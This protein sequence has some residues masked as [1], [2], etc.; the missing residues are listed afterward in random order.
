MVIRDVVSFI[1]FSVSVGPCSGRKSLIPFY[2]TVTDKPT[3]SC[4]VQPMYLRYKSS[5]KCAGNFSIQ[6]PISA[7]VIARMSG[8]VSLRGGVGVRDG[9]WR[10][11]GCA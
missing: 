1:Y 11:R 10:P 8:S 3:L 9:L 4:S 7:I 2:K 6:M 5:R